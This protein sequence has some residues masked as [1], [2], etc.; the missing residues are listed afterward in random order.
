MKRAIV[1]IVMTVV[2]M[3]VFAQGSHLDVSRAKLKNP[4][5]FTEKAPGTFSR[6][7]PA[8][9]MVGHWALTFEVTPLGGSPFDV[10]LVDHATG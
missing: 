3:A 1:A 7:A 6:S 4:S 10:T 2:P 8:L 9:V 5:T